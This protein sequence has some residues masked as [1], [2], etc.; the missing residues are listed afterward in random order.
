M[1]LTGPLCRAARALTQ[2]SRAALAEASGVAK[3]DIRAFES[4]AESLTAEARTALA[5]TLDRAGAVLLAE[6]NM[7]V[8]V[9]LRFT[10]RDVRQ[11]KRLEG[12]GGNVGEDDV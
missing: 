9:R 10:A 5:S 4:G 11:I 8:G 7:G 1:E 12:E 6:D 3:A 2:I